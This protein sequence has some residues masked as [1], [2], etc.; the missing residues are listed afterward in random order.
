[1]PLEHRFCPRSSG[2]PIPLKI[3][4]AVLEVHLD[5]FVGAAQ[6]ARVRQEPQR[7]RCP[8]FS[9][10]WVGDREGNVRPPYERDASPECNQRP[11]A[12]TLDRDLEDPSG[13]SCG[14]LGGAETPV[15]LGDADLQLGR[16]GLGERLLHHPLQLVELVKVVG[17]LVI[18][19]KTPVL[20]LVA[21]DEVIDRLV[22]AL[23]SGCRPAVLA[24]GGALGPHDSRW[25]FQPDPPVDVP[26]T[27]PVVLVVAVEDGDLVAEE[28]SGLCPPVGD[29]RLRLREL[30]L[31]LLLQELAEL[32]L[33]LLGLAS[34]PDEP[35]Q[36][37]VGISRFMWMS[38]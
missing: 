35:E 3:L 9:H 12:F 37:V 18:L 19:D 29:Q 21:H 13:S 5:T 31:E 27:V 20:Q 25:H 24:V 4:Q 34:W 23:H 15:D 11:F 26:A 1:M 36:E 8:R 16:Q 17:H 33:D 6:L 30:Q 32:A 22:D 7:Q 28:T 2:Y 38:A 14:L 10:G